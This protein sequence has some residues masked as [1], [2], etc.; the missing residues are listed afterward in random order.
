MKLFLRCFRCKN[1]PKK[2]KK[3]IDLSKI[4]F[5]S[6]INQEPNIQNKNSLN[7][8]DQNKQINNNKENKNNNIEEN[9]RDIL[10]TDDDNKGE[11]EE[12]IKKTNES[13]IT[14]EDKN[15]ENKENNEN[16]LCSKYGLNLN[17]NIGFDIPLLKTDSPLISDFEKNIIFTKGNLME[18]FDK[19]WNLDKYKKVWDKD[20]LIIEIRSEGTDINGEF[21]LIKITYKQLKS[22]LKENS[23]IQSL[24]D[25]LYIP[26]LRL[27]W[28][29]VLKSLEVLDGDIHSNYVLS[30]WANSPAFFMSERDNIE[31]K[32]IFKNK[33]GNTF[34]VISS[35]VPVDLF[36]MQKDIVRITNYINYYKV[37]DYDDDYIYFYSLNQT[38]FKMPLPQFVIN[39]TLP[40]TTK[41][42]QLDL[43]KFAS[44]IK[45][46]KN[47]KT[48]I[49]NNNDKD[50]SK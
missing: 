43:E 17:E 5:R 35:S 42:W 26:S 7:L 4:N 15:N 48:I 14:E 37:E 44:E 45:Y 47:S 23:D 46:D 10:I 24:I 27:K 6:F 33:E 16:I 3:I 1:H 22:N 41:K 20:N 50:E 19:Y 18:L 40:T 34:Y 13:L 36:P 38:D 2:N 28:D 25:F 21:N 49:E 30:S 32:F 29:K 31:K 12:K 8:I 9:K 11:K 39:V